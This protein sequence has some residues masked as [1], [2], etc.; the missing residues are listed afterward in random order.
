VPQYFTVREAAAYLHVS[1]SFL[2][3]KRTSAEGPRYHKLGRKVVY[4]SD[5]LDRWRGERAR[6]STKTGGA[7]RAPSRRKRR[8]LK[9]DHVGA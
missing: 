3:Q 6:L 9:G 8:R 7:P 4:A 5:D 2:N 1:A